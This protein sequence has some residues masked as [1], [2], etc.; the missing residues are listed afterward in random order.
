LT[1]SVGQI[2]L[3]IMLFLF[4]VALASAFVHEYP[5]E[6]NWMCEVCHQSLDVITSPKSSLL[7]QGTPMFSMEESILDM[8]KVDGEEFSTA[9]SM[10]LDHLENAVVYKTLKKGTN[11]D[12]CVSINMCDDKESEEYLQEYQEFE[13]PAVNKNMIR[14]FN[15]MKGR[16]W[17]MGVNEKFVN[18]TLNDIRIL[19]G[20]I[21]DPEHAYQLPEKKGGDQNVK[22]GDAFD[23]RDEWP[24]CADVIGH[25]RD[26]SACGSCWAFGSTESY[27]DRLCIKTNDTTILSAADTNSCCGFV[28]CQSMGCNGGQPTLAW[29][30]FASA[31]VVTGGDYQ[32]DTTCVPYQFPP[33]SH[34]VDPTPGYPACPSDDYSTPTCLRRC[35]NTDYDTAYASDKHTAQQAYSLRSV[36]KIMADIQQYGSATCAFTV[37]EDF[38][39]Y[40]SGVYVHTTGR[41]LGGHAVK[42]VGWGVEDGVDYW[43]I[44]NSWNPTWGDKGYFKIKRG[45][46]ECGIEG[47]VSAGVP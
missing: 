10:F 6:A 1:L 47:Q 23:P 4:L 22:L 45:V 43:L 40:K 15:N 38:P 46:N 41:A 14:K 37:Y 9:C 16:S 20:S 11:E 2:N 31:G 34:H 27:N 5:S 18:A 32:D 30:W 19:L 8:C 39:N 28:Q 17:T 44:A 3:K 12:F 25:I 36:S 7:L 26:Q 21:V 29:K 42:M 33:C 24:Q 13:T 35:T